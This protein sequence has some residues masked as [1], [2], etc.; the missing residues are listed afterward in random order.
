MLPPA[1]EFQKRALPAPSSLGQLTASL[2]GRGRKAETME[3]WWLR[4]LLASAQRARFRRRGQLIARRGRT[5]AFVEVSNAARSTP[6]PGRSTN[7][8]CGASPLRRWPAPRYA[9]DATTSAL[10]LVHRAS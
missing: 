4:L 2:R 3:A 7:T 9:R 5:L 6:R 10:M 1:W 8:G